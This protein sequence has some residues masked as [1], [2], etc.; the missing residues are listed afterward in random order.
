MNSGRNLSSVDRVLA[1]SQVSD[2]QYEFIIQ[3]QLMNKDELRKTLKSRNMNAGAATTKKVDL[4][5]ALARVLHPMEVQELQQQYGLLQRFEHAQAR[6]RAWARA[7]APAEAPVPAGAPAPAE[8]PVPAEAQAQIH[9]VRGIVTNVV[10]SNGSNGTILIVVM[11]EKILPEISNLVNLIDKLQL[12][13]DIKTIQ[14][15]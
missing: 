5:I 9:G 3:L 13:I 6:A 14:A 2:V 10:P 12:G 11:N 1:Q 15:M 7:P 8:A 4:L